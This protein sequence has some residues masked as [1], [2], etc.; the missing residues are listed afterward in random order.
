MP[1]LPTVS[2]IR[3]VLQANLSGVSP[4][5]VAAPWQALSEA[6]GTV[7]TKLEEGEV[8]DAAIEGGNATYRDPN[9][10]LKVDLRPNYSPQDR[11]FNRAA[12]GGFLAR[13]QVEGRQ[14]LQSLAQSADGDVK[15]YDTSS[16]TFIKEK[17]RSVP[18][19]LK[20]PVALALSEDRQQY[21]AG[22]SEQNRR[23]TIEVSK[24]DILS[25]KKMLEDD[26]GSL[27]LN[28]GITSPQ[29]LAK[30]HELDGLL[31]ELASNRD[32]NYSPTQ[33]NIDRQNILATNTAYAFAGQAQRFMDAGD[34]AGAMKL[35]NTVMTDTSLHLSP[36]ERYHFSGQIREQIRAYQ[37]AQREQAKPYVEDAKDMVKNF[38]Q[39][40]GFDDDKVSDTANQLRSLG[41][42]LDAS[43]LLAARDQYRDLQSRKSS[44]THDLVSA[45][46]QAMNGTSSPSPAGSAPANTM[47]S[48]IEQRNGLPAGYLARTMQIESGGRNLGPNSAGAEGYFQFV[49]ST[50]ARMG[51]NPR[52][53]N[54]SAD[55]AGRLA[56]ESARYLRTGLGRDP[57]GA[58]LYLAHQQGAGGAMKLLSN[59]DA[60][61][62]SLVGTKAIIQ[63]GGREDM[64]AAQFVQMWANKFNGT[65]G[66]AT[67]SPGQSDVPSWVRDPE[68]I[69]GMRD[70]VT[71]RYEQ[72]YDT[73]E[74][75]FKQGTLPSSDDM[76]TLLQAIPMFTSDSLRQKFSTLLSSEQFAENLRQQYPDP[77]QRG[78]VVDAIQSSFQANGAD[79]AQ[80]QAVQFY[81]Q[82]EQAIADAKKNDAVGYAAKRYGGVVGQLQPIQTADTNALAGALQARDR[83][84][85]TLIDH[86]EIPAPVSAFSKSDLPTLTSIWRSGD[87]SQLST[88][89]ANMLGNLSP[90]TFVATLE[91]PKY[92]EMITGAALSNDPIRH[93][94]AMQQLDALA[95]QVGLG[96]VEHA[97]SSD[98]VNRLQDW[99]AHVRYSSD[100]EVADWL[101]QRN[102]PQWQKRVEPLVRAGETEARKVTAQTIA[103]RISG[104][105]V[106]SATPPADADTLRMMQN[107]F[108]SLTGDRNGSIND[109]GKAQSQAIERMKEKWGTSDALGGRMMLYPPENF[110]PAFNGSHDWIGAQLQDFAKQRGID[111]SNMALIA[112]TKTEGNISNRQPPGYLVAKVDPAT[113]FDNVIT[114]EAG[115]PLRVFFDPQEGQQHAA[116]AAL[117]ARRTRNDP[118]LVINRNT[119][120]GPLLP[121]D[122]QNRQQ[123]INE[124]IDERQKAYEHGGQQADEFLN[125][126]LR[127][128]GTGF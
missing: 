28:G 98:I 71:R 30:Q 110:Y 92:Q 67:V 56:A 43:N 114:D 59:P 31:N 38:K 19:P 96:E 87:S 99:Q 40:V 13:A 3:N 15:A 27:A 116:S 62:A 72:S 66:N 85:G 102:D 103:N 104:N 106:M 109:T 32:F 23:R 35:A 12:M 68:Y 113:G 65:A 127:D 29:Y 42:P 88:L 39:G 120:V 74:T 94:A 6:F 36:Q 90:R 91:D 20:G 61:A 57:T 2:P 48:Q 7:G 93:Q 50:A 126:Q 10:E 77:A 37:S 21:Y 105:W 123:R 69:K 84:V 25:R 8:A 111:P 46:G 44:S 81:Q 75:M 125:Q 70:S 58:E 63:N 17:L 1:N 79:V 22:V 124:I 117:E 121:D 112:D 122:M 108:V 95:S 101:K 119:A 16:S 41:R 89:T 47:F 118:W 14:G 55:G 18:D 78:A 4:Q 100:A 24:G 49:P 53:L 73:F 34:T 115:R 83:A 128:I 51:V 33:A 60:N 80:Y 107:D 82:S 86:G 11:A 45:T 97:Y 26:L 76:Q 54:S 52:D 9:G 5:A 64:T